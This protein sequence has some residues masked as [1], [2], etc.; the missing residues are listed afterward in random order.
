[1]K[2]VTYPIY[3]M[4]LLSVPK[5]VV[6]NS[7]GGMNTMLEPGDLM[8]ITDFINLLGTNPLI[9]ENDERFG[10][11]FPDMTEPYCIEF[12]SYAENI[13]E[14]HDIRYKKGVY[15]AVTGP[16]YETAAEIRAYKNMG[17]DAIGMST[18][19]ETIVANYLGIKVLGISCI[20]N[21]ATGI[22]NARHSHEKV[23]EVAKKSSITFSS[24]IT[25]IIGDM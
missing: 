7:C 25:Y 21:M 17:G 15:C 22:Q 24:F 4:K 3:M 10:P 11:R 20:T 5:L 2:Q 18:V 8:L 14:K 1:M 12:M 9:G 13:A 16:Y 19:P 6:T 23:L